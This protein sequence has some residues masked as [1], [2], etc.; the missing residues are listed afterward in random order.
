[1]K[2]TERLDELDRIFDL[3]LVL[4]GIITASLFQYSCTIIPLEIT[5]QNQTLTQQELFQEMDK[6]ITATL[7]VL[8]IPLVLLIGIW[9]LNRISLKTKIRARRFVSEFSYIIAFMILTFDIDAFL[10]VSF[11]GFLDP[12]IHLL[13]FHSYFTFLGPSILF[14]TMRFC[15]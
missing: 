6:S 3:L 5:A 11:S 7:R 9:I 1:M 10:G 13:D 8:F 15:S 12:N 14:T 4:L 2:P